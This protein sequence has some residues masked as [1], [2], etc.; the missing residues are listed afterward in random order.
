MRESHIRVRVVYMQ[1]VVSMLEPLAWRRSSVGG[2]ICVQGTI[3]LWAVTMFWVDELSLGRR[4]S[5]RR[6]SLSQGMH[7][8]QTEVS[9]EKDGWGV[10]RPL[11]VPGEVEKKG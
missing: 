6:P 5:V 3:C 8:R 9:S 10:R 4:Q 11:P 7:A 1:R 2:L